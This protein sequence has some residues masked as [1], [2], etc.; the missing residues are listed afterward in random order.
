MEKNLNLL[1][2][3]LGSVPTF[4]FRM[5]IF[6]FNLLLRWQMGALELER[7][8]Q[9][10]LVTVGQNCYVGPIC[11]NTKVKYL[12]CSMDTLNRFYTSA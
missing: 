5:M 1:E 10:K 2:W 9:N 7:E 12:Y 4:A 8:R 6:F 3:I 11:L